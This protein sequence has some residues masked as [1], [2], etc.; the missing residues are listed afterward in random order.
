MD[1]RDDTDFG[2]L[3]SPL[4]PTADLL[5]H[6]IVARLDQNADV[7]QVDHPQSIAGTDP[8]DGN[9]LVSLGQSPES[10]TPRF[11]GLFPDHTFWGFI[12]QGL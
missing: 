11:N 4:V 3:I 12:N 6:E 1:C 7:L 9:V 2:Y 8:W 5:Y 10:L